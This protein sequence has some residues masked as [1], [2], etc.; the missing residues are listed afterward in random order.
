MDLGNSMDMN[1]TMEYGRDKNDFKI[2][3]DLESNVNK[4]N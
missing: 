3:Q 4:N 2:L 1:A